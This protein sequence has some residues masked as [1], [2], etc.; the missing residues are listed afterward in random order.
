MVRVPPD[1]LRPSFVT[2]WVSESRR[3]QNLATH[4]CLIKLDFT[5][6]N[7]DAGSSFT[8]GAFLRTH[9][10]NVKL[11][12]WLNV[13]WVWHLM[14]GAVAWSPGWVQDVKYPLELDHNHR[15]PGQPAAGD[16]RD[17][18]RPTKGILQWLNWVN[19]QP[20]DNCTLWFH[21]TLI[22]HPSYCLRSKD[23][24]QTWKME[25]T[26]NCVRFEVFFCPDS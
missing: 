8:N 16:L 15:Q 26:F 12:D 21:L 17:F 4:L 25:R 5:T 24:S 6:N 14:S 19:I 20:A 1:S 22:V 7:K 9:L 2:L 10:L 13:F 18:A 23:W 3:C 11:E